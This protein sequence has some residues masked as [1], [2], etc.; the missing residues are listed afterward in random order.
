MEQQS[1]IENAPILP[2]GFFWDWIDRVPGPQGLEEV[3]WM[4]MLHAMRMLATARYPH[5]YDN[6]E[7]S[8]QFKEGV[9][10]GEPYEIY[11]DR[12]ASIAFGLRRKMAA[13]LRQNESS[14]PIY[15]KWAFL[16]T[17]IPSVRENGP[18]SDACSI[19][20]DGVNM[21]SVLWNPHSSEAISTQVFIP[22]DF[23]ALNDQNRWLVLRATKPIAGWKTFET[24]PFPKLEEIV[25]P[26]ALPPGGMSH[27]K[28]GMLHRRE[29]LSPETRPNEPE[30]RYGFRI[31]E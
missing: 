25:V 22:K 16:Y 5:R 8:Q 31:N 3:E 23:P 30:W 19:H 7:V 28:G 14:Y 24:S 10:N 4:N 26:F 15:P 27:L 6:S 2:Q 29:P 13:F 20:N 21:S 18:T 9:I 11:H 1:V 17:H 12:V